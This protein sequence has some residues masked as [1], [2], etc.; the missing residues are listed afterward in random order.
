MASLLPSEFQTLTPLEE[1][2]D[3]TNGASVQRNRRH[4]YLLQS[5]QGSARSIRY[6][7]LGTS[8]R[9]IGMRAAQRFRNFPGPAAAIPNS[10]RTKVNLIYQTSMETSRAATAEPVSQEDWEDPEIQRVGT[11]PAR[12][13]FFSFPGQG[14]SDAERT[15]R[16]ATG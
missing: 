13:S 14:S 5:A 15:G 12:A 3:G 2:E 8:R 4:V 10:M 6:V 7:H 11:E 1:S 16:I 9:D